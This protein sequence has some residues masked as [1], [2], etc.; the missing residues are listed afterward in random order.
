MN[1]PVYRLPAALRQIPPLPQ[2]ALRAMALI[3]DPES[4]RTALAQVLSLDQGMTGRFLS[5]VNS[6]YYGLSRR[7]TS[8]D[9]AIGF[10]GYDRVNQAVVAAS[11]LPYI[12]RPLAAYALDGAMSWHHA[13]AVASGADFIARVRGLPQTDAYVAGLLHDVGK[14]ALD[15]LLQRRSVWPTD[16]EDDGEAEAWTA[17]ERHTTG[18][19]HAEL[20][21]AI[22]RSWNLP[23]RVV[24]AVGFHHAPSEAGEDLPFAALVHIANAAAL[25]GGIGLGIDG[26]RHTLDPGAFACLAWREADMFTLIERMQSAVEDAKAMLRSGNGR[27]RRPEPPFT[28]K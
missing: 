26:L 19:D 3:R 8:V 25:M 15:I 22:V 1:Q 14:L 4:S 24:A 12:T 21:A 7:I 2:V 6:A 23:D 5:M 13:V 27:S 11:A 10:L 17:V 28:G 18:H 20:G 16:T 9:E